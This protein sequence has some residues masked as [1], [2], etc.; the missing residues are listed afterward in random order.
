MVV[1]QGSTPWRLL[2]DG[3]APGPWNMGVDEALLASARRSQLATLRFYTWDGPWLSLGYAQR[4][5]A[6]QLVACRASGVARVCAPG[7]TGWRSIVAAVACEG[8]G[9]G[10]IDSFPI[11]RIICRGCPINGGTLKRWRWQEMLGIES[12]EDSTACQPS[13]GRQ[14]S[15]MISRN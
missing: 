14:F 2:L 3:S 6:E 8:S 5:S 4:R 7:S 11:Q 1:G 12:S 10:E 13:I 9:Q 15:C